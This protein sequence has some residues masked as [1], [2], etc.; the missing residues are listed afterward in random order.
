MLSTGVVRRLCV[1]ETRSEFTESAGESEEDDNI[2]EVMGGKVEVTGS[3]A[4]AA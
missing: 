4:G 1:M 3:H 2:L